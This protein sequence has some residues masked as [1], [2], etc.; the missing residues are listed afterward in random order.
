M[1]PNQCGRLERRDDPHHR[2]AQ[3]VGPE[4]CRPVVGRVGRQP[5][6]RDQDVDDDDDRDCAE[7]AA[8][9][10]APRPPGLLGIVGDRLE[11]RVREH[12][13]RQC[14]RDVVPGRVRA[15]REIAGERAAREEDRK[16]EDHEQRLRHEVEERH[17]DA[18]AIEPRSPEETHAGD[19]CDNH[20]GSDH[21]ARPPGDRVDAEGEPEIVRDEER[22]EGDHDQVVEEEH[23]AGE[24][25]GEVVEGDAHEC[26]GASGLANRRRPLGV[27]ERDD[28]EEQ[29]DEPEDDRREA[30]RVQRDH[31]EREVDGGGDLAVRDGGERGRVEGALQLRQLARHQ[32]L[33]SK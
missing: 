19:R 18:D 11:A 29:T 1:L 22:R 28:E 31:A 7:Q 15:E 17:G 4:R 32:V 2:R 14:E 3:P 23:P 21:V 27:G 6:A 30:Q 8:W 13:E 12:G 5:D 26:C 9:Q 16:A 25:A 10:V 33:L 24:E 20:A